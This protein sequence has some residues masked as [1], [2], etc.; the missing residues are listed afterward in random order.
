MDG[1]LWNRAP[2][3]GS[4]LSMTQGRHQGSGWVPWVATE[5]LD[6]PDTNQGLYSAD[7]HT[8]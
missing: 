5:G 2:W 3:F 1:G 7:M 4:G 8:A 6:N